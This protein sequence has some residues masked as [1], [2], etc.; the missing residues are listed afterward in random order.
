MPVDILPPV[1]EPGTAVGHVTIEAS[2]ETGLRQGTLV[3]MGGGDC[4]IGAVGVNLISAGEC[5]IFGG[6]FWQ[7]ITNVLSDIRDPGMDLRINPH[8]VPG[9]N[10]AE[11]ISFFVGA[12]MRWF[13]DSFGQEEM[14]AAGRDQSMA[15]TLLEQLSE[16]VP[17]GSYGILPVFSDVMHYGHW[18]HAAPSLLNLSLD[19]E[20]SG[21]GAIFKALQENA[22][23][24]ASLNLKRVFALTGDMPRHVVFASGAAK[25]GRWCQILSDVLGLPVK[26]PKVTE[27]TALGC[28]ITASVGAGLYAGLAEASGAMVK[29]DRSYEPQSGLKQVYD[30][31]RDKW[32]LAY[33]AQLA[34][35]DSG[36]TTSMWKAP[37]L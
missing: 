14:R 5:A 19:P 30:D 23:I 15:Y 1:V 21:K 22:A 32:Q 16:G 37:G 3:V 35:V 33:A 12:A 27:A 31:V 17:A 20:R 4:Q 11:A 7:Q 6:T 36:I 34:L 9:L 2:A 18:Y 29:W 26:V 10:Q 28:A 8:A 13:R 25:S 24:V